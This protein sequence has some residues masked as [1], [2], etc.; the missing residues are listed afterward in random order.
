MPLDPKASLQIG[1][2]GRLRHLLTTEG[3]PA[4]TIGL[5]L[6]TADQFV[7]VSERD[8]KKVGPH[9]IYAND[10]ITRQGS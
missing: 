6:D 3:L 1:P 4:E 8:V 7:S 9:N 10:L 5:I 2:D